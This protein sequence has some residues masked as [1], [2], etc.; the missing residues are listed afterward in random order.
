MGTLGA[1]GTFGAWLLLRAGGDG[2][3]VAVGV[4]VGSQKKAA[5]TAAAE[6]S[7]GGGG[8]DAI[9]RDR[10]SVSFSGG[11]MVSLKHRQLRRKVKR[12]VGKEVVEP[13][14][15]AL[16]RQEASGCRCFVRRV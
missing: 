16:P 14:V 15:A 6:A 11:A 8:Q 1:S 13:A 12:Q 7:S 5:Q 9:A 4:G 10:G 3:G 2:D